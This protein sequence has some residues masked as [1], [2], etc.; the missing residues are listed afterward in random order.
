MTF[1]QVLWF[2]MIYGAIGWIIEV[3]Y[4]ALTLGKV[5]NRGF[6]N[7]PICP[8]YGIGMVVVLE[9]MQRIPANPDTG[10]AGVGVTFLVG[11]IFTT[12]I[13]LVAGWL[14]DKAFHARWWDYSD[15]PMNLNGYIC[16]LFSVIW[17]LG[18]VAAV[19]LAH[20]VIARFSLAALPIRYGWWV[21]A[22]LYLALFADTGVTVAFVIGLNRE[23]KQLETIREMLR[24]PSDRMSEQI[25][26]DTIEISNNI[27]E[28]RIQAS[29]GKAE[30][31]DNITE[32]RQEL[33]RRREEFMRETN[34]GR[35]RLLNAFPNMK[36]RLYE[37]V[38][39]ELQEYVRTGKSSGGSM[40]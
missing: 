23:L 28:Y 39:K 12:L 20:P 7:G 32:Y 4:H 31:R 10:E 34:W 30:L 35:R 29:L 2:F 8:V 9:I 13:E 33:S 27:A 6:L 40:R 19:K 24:S 38:V 5:V 21:L 22:V 11:M 37:E 36:H 14:L 26:K 17:G 16:P 25:A 15:R 1:Y 3:A 18:V